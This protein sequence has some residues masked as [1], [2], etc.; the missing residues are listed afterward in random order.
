M[1]EKSFV[2]EERIVALMRRRGIPALRVSLGIVFLWFGALK[3]LGMSP[4]SGLIQSS[5]SFM[6]YPA[7][8]LLLGTW[9]AM[10]GIGLIFKRGLRLVLPL[11]WL[12]IAGTFGAL[13]L[14]PPLLS[15]L[16]SKMP[17]VRLVAVW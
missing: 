12:Q 11:L 6:L 5:Y 4:V 1:K 2:Y 14:L 3:I 7:F 17:L 9:E 15:S 16:L 8:V 13:L 10:L